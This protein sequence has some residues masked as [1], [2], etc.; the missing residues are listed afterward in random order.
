MDS[1]NPGARKSEICKTGLQAGVWGT[2]CGSDLES[3]GRMLR[4]SFCVA[5]WRQTPL[6]ELYV[7]ARQ[8]LRRLEEV[9]P[10]FEG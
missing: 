7:L 9:P 4:Q 6:S 3:D 2:S 8:V 5:V 10:H 1:R